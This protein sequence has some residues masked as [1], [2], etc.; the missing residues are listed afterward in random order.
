VFGNLRRK[1]EKR[2]WSSSLFGEMSEGWNLAGFNGL[3]KQMV[4]MKKRKN[5]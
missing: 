3:A 5:I 4:R 2:S 1:A